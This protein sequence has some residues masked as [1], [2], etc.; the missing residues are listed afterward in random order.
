MVT[1]PLPARMPGST[2][3]HLGGCALFK[4][5]FEQGAGMTRGVVISLCDRSGVMVRPWADAG[6]E[7]WCVDLKHSIRKDRVENVGSGVIHFVWG[8]IRSWR[9]PHS[10]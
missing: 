9:P 5:A 10:V 7:C 2:F 4:P 6:F 3:G 1:F 8:D